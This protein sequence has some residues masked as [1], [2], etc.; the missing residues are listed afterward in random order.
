MR[1]GCQV[2][3]VVHTKETTFTKKRADNE[4][5][6]EI[7]VLLSDSNDWLSD[8]C[9]LNWNLINYYRYYNS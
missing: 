6:N 4:V 1:P 8:K 3:S 5:R 7:G 9:S 2:T